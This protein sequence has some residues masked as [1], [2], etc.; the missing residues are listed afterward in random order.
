MTADLDDTIDAIQ[1]EKLE[2]AR[3]NPIRIIGTT[4]DHSQAWL[5]FYH[6]FWA[7]QEGKDHLRGLAERRLKAAS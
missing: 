5:D 7:N 1:D 4:L 2:R 6:R 3:T